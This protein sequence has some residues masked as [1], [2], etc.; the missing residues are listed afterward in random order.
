MCCLWWLAKG[1][2]GRGEGGRGGG[3]VQ[4]LFAV[5]DCVISANINTELIAKAPQGPPGASYVCPAGLSCCWPGGDG[6]EGSAGKGWEGGY[7]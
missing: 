6:G 5:L 3:G 1:G 7:T 4:R 2:K